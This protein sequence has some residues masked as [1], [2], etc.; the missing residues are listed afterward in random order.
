MAKLEM[1]KDEQDRFDAWKAEHHKTCALKPGTVGDLYVFRITPTSIGDFLTVTCACGV[2]EVL[3][4]GD[5][6]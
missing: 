1:D 2:K 5:D 4:D 6:F 3:Q